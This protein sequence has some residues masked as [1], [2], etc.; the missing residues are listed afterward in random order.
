MAH[1]YIV[2]GE[3]GYEFNDDLHKR[4]QTKQEVTK[5]NKLSNLPCKLLAKHT[6]KLCLELHE[7]G[8]AS[9]Q[10]FTSHDYK[11]GDAEIIFAG[12]PH[13]EA[14]D[15]AVMI[16]CLSERYDFLGI[17]IGGIKDNAIQILESYGYQKVSEDNHKYWEK[18]DVQVDIDGDMYIEQVRVWVKTFYLG[19]CV[20]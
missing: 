11:S 1:E 4:K 16:N 2:L 7:L 10:N 3:R 6:N 14:K 12:Y 5:I 17:K 20:Y 9:F 13:D 18:L 15:Y 19:N 8:F